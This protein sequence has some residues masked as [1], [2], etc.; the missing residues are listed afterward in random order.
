MLAQDSDP[1]LVAELVQAY[2]KEKLCMFA[3]YNIS[4]SSSH[5]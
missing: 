4:P 2:L 5:V 3:L 1:V